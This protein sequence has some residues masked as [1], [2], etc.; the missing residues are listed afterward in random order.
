[1]KTKYYCIIILA[2]AGLNCNAQEAVTYWRTSGLVFNLPKSCGE[3]PH[4]FTYKECYRYDSL[5]SDME[6]VEIGGSKVHYDLPNC[7]S[8]SE[9]NG[10][11]PT[12]RDKKKTTIT[13]SLSGSLSATCKGTVKAKLGGSIGNAVER[14][15]EVSMPPQPIKTEGCR[16][17]EGDYYVNYNRQ[18]AKVNSYYTGTAVIQGKEITYP[19]PSLPSIEAC[20]H[21]GQQDSATSPTY[22]STVNYENYGSYSFALKNQKIEKCEGQN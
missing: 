8:T 15:T 13:Y 9:L 5:S 10:F 18:K 4:S 1:M 17:H 6:T 3:W 12:W 19:Y 22:S 2:L 20:S 7:E 11:S 16:T 14:E 21:T